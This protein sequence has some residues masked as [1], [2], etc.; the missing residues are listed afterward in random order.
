MG[1][2]GSVRI[3]KS[4]TDAAAPTFQKQSSV[5]KRPVIYFANV[6]RDQQ[7]RLCKQEKQEMGPATPGNTGLPG[8]G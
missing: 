7:P 4:S 1:K 5:N 8:R 3:R 6:T 2:L